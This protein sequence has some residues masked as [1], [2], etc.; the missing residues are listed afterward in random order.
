MVSGGADDLVVPVAA[1]CAGLILLIAIVI[2][3]VYLVKKKKEEANNLGGTSFNTSGFNAETYNSQSPP[4]LSSGASFYSPPSSGG[5]FGGPGMA[6][7]VGFSSQRPSIS[8]P[9]ETFSSAALQQQDPINYSERL[10]RLWR[11]FLTLYRPDN[12]PQYN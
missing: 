8:A 6:E 5:S 3:V 7:S 12:I 11:C 4:L 9:P 1:A 10:A 2:L